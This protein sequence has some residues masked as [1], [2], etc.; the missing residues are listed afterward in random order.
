MNK[1]QLAGVA[2]GLFVIIIIGII[3]GWS[4]N[5]NTAKPVVI[6]VDTVYTD[7]A[8]TSHQEKKK[9]KSKKRNKSVNTTKQPASRPYLDQPVD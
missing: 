2:L 9:A 7:T 6:T 8:K 1:P 5:S 3:V 4:G